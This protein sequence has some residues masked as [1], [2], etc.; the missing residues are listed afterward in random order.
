MVLLA[1]KLNSGREGGRKKG[2]RE[3]KEGRGGKGR[4]DKEY[5]REVGA[6]LENY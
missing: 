3:S 4:G 5:G 2:G 1:S 6:L